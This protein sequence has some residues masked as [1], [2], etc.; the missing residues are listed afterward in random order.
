LDAGGDDSE[1]DDE[2]QR[3]FNP[4][5]LDENY[6]LPY[7]MRT[8]D[9]T[10][11]LAMEG[12]AFQFLLEARDQG[13]QIDGYDAADVLREVLRRGRVFAR[14]SPKQKALLVEELQKETGEMVGM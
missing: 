6:M 12:S 2:V 14:M 9:L 8:K 11:Q 5:I 10:L 3:L 13:E 4:D 7:I 1:T